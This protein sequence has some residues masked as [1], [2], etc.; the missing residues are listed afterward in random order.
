MMKTCI[1]VL[2]ISLSVTVLSQSLPKVFYIAGFKSTSTDMQ[3]WKKQFQKNQNYSQHLTFEAFNLPSTQSSKE[4]VLKD[5]EKL[6]DSIVQEIDQSPSGSEFVLVGHSSGSALTNEVAK[7]VQKKSKIKLVVLDGFVPKEV[8]KEVEVFCW[9]AT[10]PKSG[11]K[12]LNTEGMK[13]CTRYQEIK[14]VNCRTKQCLHFSIVNSA[15]LFNLSDLS[16]G[17]ENLTPNLSWLDKFIKLNPIKS[18][19]PVR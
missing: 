4:A 6:V 18:G 8:P 7:R 1:F 15:V 2:M 5:G 17:Y 9:S 14:S 10:N 19:E 11:L 12:S 3:S 16:E 13:T